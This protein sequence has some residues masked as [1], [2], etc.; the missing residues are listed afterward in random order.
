MPVTPWDAG[1]YTILCSK[2]LTD[3]PNLGDFLPGYLVY[4]LVNNN[5]TH[6]ALIG[7]Y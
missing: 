3:S 7:I 1:W 6:Q 5:L 2:S 4:T